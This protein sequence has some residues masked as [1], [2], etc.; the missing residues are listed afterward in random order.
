MSVAAD[1]ETMGRLFGEITRLNLEAA[2]GLAQGKPLAG[3]GPLFQAKDAAT[4]K[5]MALLPLLEIVQPGAEEMTAV[6]A[7]QA[8]Q[9]E[10][11]RSETKLSELLDK[12]V[13]QRGNAGEAY[14]QNRAPRPATGW[15]RRG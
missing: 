3:L 5:L 7:A 1:L 11:V 14:Q 15:E 8:A 10:A 12:M 9:R 2:A 4:A 13:S 6:F